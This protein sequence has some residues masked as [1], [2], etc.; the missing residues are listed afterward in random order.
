M[1]CGMVLGIFRI[2]DNNIGTTGSH[3]NEIWMWNVVIVTTHRVNLVRYKGN[4]AIAGQSLG[5]SV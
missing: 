2:N 3:E 4:S 1:W 5:V